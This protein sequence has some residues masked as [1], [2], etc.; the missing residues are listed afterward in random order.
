[1]VLLAWY[2]ITKTVSYWS[3]LVSLGFQVVNFFVLYTDGTNWYFQVPLFLANMLYVMV[4]NFEIRLLAEVAEFA[5]VYK[6][7][8]T[9]F[10][11][12]RPP[13][14]NL[15]YSANL[16]SSFYYRMKL[17]EK[18]KLHMAAPVKRS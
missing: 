11:L 15:G 7:Y 13:F 6:D 17:L 14:L 16:Y 3:L 9:Q 12:S 4:V 1:M 5:S 18:N 10:H 2:S 8:E